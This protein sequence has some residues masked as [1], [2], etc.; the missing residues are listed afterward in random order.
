MKIATWNVNGIRASFDKGL[1]DF[2]KKY[3]P[4]ILC[5]QET[6]AHPDQLDK[7]LHLLDYYPHREW[8]SCGVKKGYS[9]TAIFSKKPPVRTRKGMGIKKFDREGRI[10]ISE[11]DSFILLDIYFPN[12]AMTEERHLFKQEFLYRLTLFVKSLEK[13]ERKGLVIVGD[14][15]TAL[16]DKDVYDPVALKTTS[17]F[18]PEER[19]WFKSFLNRGFIDVFRHFYPEKESAFTWWSYRENARKKNRGWRIDHIC[20]SEILKEKLKEITI[21]QEQMGSDHCPL[22]MEIDL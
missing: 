14:Y 6:K 10:L 3:N 11:Y 8:S 5:L 20:V 1:E 15:N 22:L 19:K 9:G 17:G 13:K 16:L 18:L 21:H 12:G 7:K 2:I 4:D